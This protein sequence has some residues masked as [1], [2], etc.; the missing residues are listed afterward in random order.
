MVAE[1]EHRTAKLPVPIPVF[2]LYWTAWMDAEGRVQFR[3][4]WYDAD[5]RLQTALAEAMRRR[6]E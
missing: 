5:R 1:G 4:D 6:E 3:E 2:L